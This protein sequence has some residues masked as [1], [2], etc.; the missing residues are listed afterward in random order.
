MIQPVKTVPE[1]LRDTQS[2]DESS[3]KPIRL[4]ACG[5]PA[6]VDSIIHRLH[7]EGF[8]QMVEWSKPLPSPIEGEII[9]ILTRYYEG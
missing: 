9:R 3:R 4:L 5:T 1:L 7:I 6:G 2:A 8:A